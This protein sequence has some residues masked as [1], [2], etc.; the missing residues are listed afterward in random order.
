MIA[1][2]YIEIKKLDLSKKSLDQCRFVRV[3]LGDRMDFFF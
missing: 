2:K 1:R 3:W